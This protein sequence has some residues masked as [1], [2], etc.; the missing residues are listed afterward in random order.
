MTHTEVQ[1]HTHSS[2]LSPSSPSMFPLTANSDSRTHS[3]PPGTCPERFLC[4]TAHLGP[5]V[6]RAAMHPCYWQIPHLPECMGHPQIDTQVLML[7]LLS[8][9]LMS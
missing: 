5:R 4:S 9:P 1:T 8:V 7:S 3:H 2:T 6:F